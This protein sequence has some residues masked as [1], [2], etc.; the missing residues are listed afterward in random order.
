MW[1]FGLLLSEWTV[2]DPSCKRSIYSVR[3]GMIWAVQID[4]ITIHL[5]A[6]SSRE[7]N[8]RHTG[9]LCDNH[10]ETAVPRSLNHKSTQGKFYKKDIFTRTSNA[11]RKHSSTS[12]TIFSRHIKDLIDGSGSS[13]GTLLVPTLRTWWCPVLTCFKI[14]VSP[15]E[16]AV[17]R[18]LQQGAAHKTPECAFER[19]L[20]DTRSS[21]AVLLYPSMKGSNLVCNEAAT[22]GSIQPAIV[23]G[24]VREFLL[25]VA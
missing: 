11:W 13:E 4:Q 19:T 10:G 5:S 25:K 3:H 20:D 8:I 2:L 24:H 15:Y 14:T 7:E 12:P 21:K 1:Y 9:A 23:D 17:L 6:P 22:C 16:R 18:L